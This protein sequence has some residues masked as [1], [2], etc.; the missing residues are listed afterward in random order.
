[1][2]GVVGVAEDAA[3]ALVPEIAFE[4]AMRDLRIPLADLIA[5]LVA[6]ELPYVGAHIPAA[7][8][9]EVPICLNR[10][11]FAV[12]VVIVGIRSPDQILGEGGTEEDAGYV[13]GETGS[14]AVG[15]PDDVY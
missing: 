11:Q 5:C 6:D 7:Q 9:V 15:L 3:V 2:R 10:G 1:M 13:V 8:S 14:V 12:V 4:T